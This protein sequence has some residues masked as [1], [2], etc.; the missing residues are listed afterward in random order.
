MTLLAALGEGGMATVYLASL[1]L[2]ASA[3]LVAVKLLRPGLP[4]H[5]YRT[6]FLDEAKL[7]LRLHH[8]N[9][10]E[11]R[12]AGEF[13]QQLFI[14]MSLV[15]GRD[16]ADIWDR[17]AAVG[18]AFPVPIAVHIIREIL[19]GLHYAHTFP[20][21]G[22]VH[23]DVS[24]S[25][26][27]IDWTGSV[28]LADFGLATSTLKGS[29]T[30]P[31][32]V[33][34]KVGY[35]SPEQAR[36][37]TLDGRA[38]VYA[39]G[40]VLWELLT[41]RPLRGGDGVDTEDV[42]HFTAPP[43][44]TYSSRVDPELDAVVMK[45]LARDRE[46]R[47]LSAHEFMEALGGWLQ[48]NYPGFTGQEAAADFMGMLF[49]DAAAREAENREYLLMEL[50]GTTQGVSSRD[51]NKDTLVDEEEF[52]LALDNFDEGADVSMGGKK[53]IPLPPDR[54]Q[55]PP[56]AVA[57]AAAN[58]RPRE[59]NKDDDPVNDI[60]YIQPGTIIAD[61][62]CV[63]SRIGRGGMGTVYLGE[64]TTVGRRVAIK[65]L[66][67]QW[68]RNELVAKRFRAEARA[69]SAAG[70]H[71]IIEVFDAGQLP[72]GRLY[73]VMEYLTGRNLYDEIQELGSLPVGRAVRIIR[74]ISRAIRAAHDVGIIHRDL[75]P[76]NVM[77]VPMPEGEG[78]YVKV[79]DFGIS[80][81]AERVEG[82][83]RLTI[84]GHA[85]G[86]PEYMAPEQAKGK[87]ATE[88]FDIY[89]LGVMLFE[90]LVG[91]PPFVSNNMVEIMARKATERAP[92]LGDRRPDLPRQLIKLVD[93][94]LEIDPGMR[95][96]SARE[97]LTRLEEV[98]RLLPPDEHDLDAD[99]PGASL[100]VAPVRRE[101]LLSVPG[102]VAMAK[103]PDKV[104]ATVPMPTPPPPSGMT[105]ER[106]R[107]LSMAAIVVFAASLLW[108]ALRWGPSNEESAGDEGGEVA[109]KTTGEPVNKPLPTNDPPTKKSNPQWGAVVVD[110]KL[111]NPPET[112]QTDPKAGD[113]DGETKDEKGDKEPGKK[114]ND[115][116]PARDPNS[117]FCKQ[118]VDKVKSARAG[119]KPAEMLRFL[120]AEPGCWKS[121]A[122][123]AK[124]R[125][126]AYKELEKW[127]E[128]ARAGRGQTDAD[129]VRWVKFCERREAG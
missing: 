51:D 102:P 59:K 29:L 82:E 4:D 19:R 105:Y 63:V 117:E 101:K 112:K 45:A 41:G 119:G 116:K 84:P 122:E 93:D 127:K 52:E 16:L 104:A 86:T 23:R 124:L 37:E 65:V 90:C 80:A 70:H 103:E 67:H 71:N 7:V 50:A 26:I 73:L 118:T 10:V 6:R 31:G 61:R 12:E 89:A 115:P 17:C 44:S 81:G 22:L 56:A 20:G 78:E 79:L 58:R 49:G 32:V 111:L 11:V 60:E 120:N 100:V 30:V 8:P 15:E 34:G 85:L 64:H 46:D 88:F 75:K 110:P 1:G 2:G 129:V 76:D 21:L 42:S 69:A 28:L 123:S 5:D 106:Q 13:E 91:E 77:F 96:Q 14:V 36:H 35:M 3:R 109:V 55:P 33:F 128:C 24:P 40:A 99:D 9:I 83:A 43:P 97:F 27:L 126:Y 54:A 121:K 18:K 98:I 57:A 38:D 107:Q 48:R 25:N 68:S 47:Y 94:C 39:C 62:Y 113:T 74:D 72:D 114:N 95:P 125:T 66:T 108:I 92:S 87:D 53:I